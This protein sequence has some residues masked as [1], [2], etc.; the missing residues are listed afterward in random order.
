MKNWNMSGLVV[1]GICCSGKTTILDAI[2]CSDLFVNRDYSSTIILSE[3]HTQR[4]LEKKEAQEGLTLDDNINLLD[5]HVSYLESLFHPLQAM[6]WASNQR[7]NQRIPFILE[8]FHLTHATHYEHVVWEDV[9][10]I[11]RRL[12][13]LNCKLCLLVLAEEDIEREIIF[14][15]NT[16]WRDYISKFGNTNG[17]IVEYY[18]KQQDRLLEMA[19]ASNMECCILNLKNNSLDDSIDKLLKRLLGE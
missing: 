11:D 1:E 19:E 8:R 17:E 9:V 5:K 14:K 12:A 6:P 15:R 4:V 18:S 7:T 13:A 3:H 16:A 10:G 2:R